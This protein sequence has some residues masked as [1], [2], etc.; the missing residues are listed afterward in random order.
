[1]SPLSVVEHPTSNQLPT[2]RASPR[3]RLTTSRN[4]S[5]VVAPIP[6]PS[7]LVVVA[8]EAPHSHRR[9]KKKRNQ[10]LVFSSQDSSHHSQLS[11]QASS[12]QSPRSVQRE[13]LMT[14]CAS[15]LSARATPPATTASRRTTVRRDSRR[16]HS[17]THSLTSLDK[18]HQSA[19]LGAPVA[20]V[21][22]R[23]F[24]I[25]SARWT[26]PV[27]SLMQMASRTITMMISFEPD[28]LLHP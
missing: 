17:V 27:T 25:L 21:K 20:Q 22:R 26:A 10:A 16:S 11:S 23:M 7:A 14:P 8:S 6:S 18:R 13:P 3:P 28:F 19:T 24:L 1:M 4:Y 9:R 5:R 12:L 15:H 2:Q